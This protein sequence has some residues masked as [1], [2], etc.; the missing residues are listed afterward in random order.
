MDSQ[1]VSDPEMGDSIKATADPPKRDPIID[2]NEVTI[3]QDALEDCENYQKSQGTQH[4]GRPSSRTKYRIASLERDLALL[5]RIFVDSRFAPFPKEV[6]YD[7]SSESSHTSDYSS[8]SEEVSV[9]LDE[10]FEDQ[11]NRS[12]LVENHSIE[13]PLTENQ[14]VESQAV[15]SQAVE[16]QP[17]ESPPVESQPVENPP[18][19]N[20]L[21]ENQPILQ[22]EAS[23][24]QPI[25]DSDKDSTA[26]IDESQSSDLDYVI[27]SHNEAFFEVYHETSGISASLR[28]AIIQVLQEDS[29]VKQA[30]STV[31]RKLTSRG[32]PI[33]DHVTGGGTEPPS[34]PMMVRIRSRFLLDILQDIT[35]APL[36]YIKKYPE[37]REY[38]KVDS[39]S[40]A[41][42]E[43]SVFLYPFKLFI[44]YES[45]IRHREKALAAEFGMEGSDGSGQT[46][47]ET[48]G[49]SEIPQPLQSTLEPMHERREENKS[50]NSAESSLFKS[51]KAYLLLN[52]LIRL[53]DRY[54]SS[55]F[56]LRHNLS[57]GETTT[58]TFE[59]LWLLFDLG[60]LVFIRHPG[61]NRSGQLP[62][63]SRVTSFTGGRINSSDRIN[64]SD[65][66]SVG[67]NSSWGL[68]GSH[69]KT[70]RPKEDVSG[71]FQINTYILESDGE[72]FG[73]LVTELTIPHWDGERAIH[74]LE[75]FPIRFCR[76]GV[77]F[78][79]ESLDAWKHELV[80]SGRQFSRLKPGTVKEYH[81]IGID[82][83]LTE[84]MYRSQVIIDL[85]MARQEA[86]K[87]FL[88]DHPRKSVYIPHAISKGITLSQSKSKEIESILNFVYR[89]RPEQRD[90][91]H[92]DV[93]MDYDL[94][95]AN[96]DTLGLSSAKFKDPD[97]LKNNEEDYALFPR[98]V[99][100]FVLK[101]HKWVN[102]S[103]DKLEVCKHESELWD[104]LQLPVGY[105]DALLSLMEV[106]VRPE[107]F[108][109]SDFDLVKAKG[110]GTT[111]LLHGHP[112]VGKTFTAEAI[113]LYTG[114]ALYS[115]TCG[116]LGEDITD[117]VD[118]LQTIL[119]RGYKWGCILVLDEA[120]VLFLER[121]SDSIERNR[122]IS[123]FLR[124]IEEYPGIWFLTTNRAKEIDRAIVSRVTLPL[125]YPPLNREATGKI[126]QS[127]LKD[128]HRF[129]PNTTAGETRV[130]IKIQSSTRK[131]WKGKYDEAINKHK[132]WWS[133][134][135]I[136]N[137]FRRAVALAMYECQ[138]QNRRQMNGMDRGSA[139]NEKTVRVNCGH[140]DAVESLDR[141]F[142]E[143]L[144]DMVLPG[145]VIMPAKDENP[146]NGDSEEYETP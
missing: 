114:R 24:N 145:H 8:D 126:W 95:L 110:I 132:A 11:S 7:T 28:P 104:H 13:N 79:N 136:Q 39:E 83:N 16:S 14:P 89:T 49:A 3:Q 27:D 29:H 2:T 78:P 10:N 123:I 52:L 34:K 61:G 128:I 98:R 102:V 73:P 65:K 37:S 100:G 88:G 46:M 58:I 47:H 106:H 116:D 77:D 81:G 107:G 135:Q 141:C 45:E 32:I 42:H 25:E 67:A 92:D 97:A 129:V 131:W 101:D 1:P 109:Q 40:V 30:R 140:F 5:K 56:A 120:D 17:V 117:I 19:E 9:Q 23:E 72:H 121:T 4:N 51:R 143:H 113:A 105:K 111:V 138:S 86:P 33:L 82:E 87:L 134:R 38:L 18:I 108:V 112:G 62:R 6:H 91:V 76:P 115:F 130:V 43:S 55:V 44:R 35:H 59:N 85:S 68:W 12:Q 94:A 57:K 144:E 69:A 90:L 71:P 22:D 84:Q 20:P 41:A 66:S 122:V 26:I 124:L 64:L 119:Y 60:E 133:G 103:V 75:C 80:Q 21:I 15:E 63:L 93:A 36:A 70:K 99:S 48:P 74:D 31:S 96:R 146:D 142:H 53:F 139:Q 54:L 125:F 50:S 137:S 127:C 118:N